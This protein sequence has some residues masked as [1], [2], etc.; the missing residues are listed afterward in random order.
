MVSETS[1][2]NFSSIIMA[3]LGDKAVGGVM[4]LVGLLIWIYYT[5]WTMVTVS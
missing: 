5:A 3:T 1:A 4:M 2:R